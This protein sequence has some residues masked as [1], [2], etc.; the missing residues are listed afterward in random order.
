MKLKA[1]E[2]VPDLRGLT[3]LVPEE[4]SIAALDA[5]VAFG[6]P[7]L[8]DVLYSLP[9]GG[10]SKLSIHVEKLRRSLERHSR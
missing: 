8:S 3:S 7:E 5:L 9:V 10:T 6:D 1:S 4:V 2:I